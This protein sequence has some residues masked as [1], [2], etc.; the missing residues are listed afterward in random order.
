[1]Q[2]PRI[3][4]RLVYVEAVMDK[5]V[6]EQAFLWIL[7]FSIVNHYFTNVTDLC[8]TTSEVYNRFHQLAFYLNLSRGFNSNMTQSKDMHL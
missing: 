6:M 8:V 5:V 2:K 3:K 4:L 7:Q 1:M